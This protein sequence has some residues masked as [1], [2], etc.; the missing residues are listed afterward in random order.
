MESEQTAEVAT[1]H[2]ELPADCDTGT[3][4][5]VLE[6][7]SKATAAA[8][9]QFPSGDARCQMVFPPA[10]SKDTRKMLHVLAQGM[11]MPTFSKGLGDERRLAVHGVAFRD[12]PEME[13]ELAAVAARKKAPAALRER[14]KQIWR[15]C[16]ADGGALSDLSLGEIEEALLSAPDES[17]LPPH[18]KDMLERRSHGGRLLAAI[19][20]GD[21]ATALAVL[22]EHPRAAFIR[23]DPPP[24]AAHGSEQDTGYYP[25]HL[26][27]LGGLGDVLRALAAQG[28]QA[29]EVRDRNYAT[30]LKVAKKAGNTAAVELLLSLGAKDYDVGQAAHK[31]AAVSIPAGRGPHSGASQS[32]GQ[33]TLTG[34]SPATGS[35]PT[36]ASG[37]SYMSGSGHV[38]HGGSGQR[39]R[40]VS[41]GESSRAGQFHQQQGQGQ[42]QGQHQNAYAHFQHHGHGHGHHQ[43][44]DS[45]GS[46]GGEGHHPHQHPHGGAGSGRDSSHGSGA[47][48]GLSNRRRSIDDHGHHHHH[49]PQPGSAPAGAAAAARD[50]TVNPFACLAAVGEAAE[51]GDG[52][53]N[54]AG[55]AGGRSRRNSAMGRPPR[56]PGSELGSG[57]VSGLG[58][59]GSDSDPSGNSG[60]KADAPGGAGAG[61]GPSGGLS[62]LGSL[63]AG[64]AKL[65]V[66][67]GSNAS[68]AGLRAQ[69]PSIM[70]GDLD[71]DSAAAA[72][73]ALGLSCKPMLP[74]ADE[75]EEAMIA[76]AAARKKAAAAAARRERGDQE[77]GD[78]QEDDADDGGSGSGPDEADGPPGGS[79]VGSMVEGGTPRKRKTRRGRRGR[80]GRRHSMPNTEEAMAAAE[81]AAR[82]VNGVASAVPI[83]MAAMSA[84][85]GLD[86]N[87]GLVGSAPNGAAGSGA[88]LLSAYAARR[89]NNGTGRISGFGASDSDD[90]DDSD[91]SGGGSRSR[92][93]G[94]PARARRH[95][96]RRTARESGPGAGSD[97]A[98]GEG[99]AAGGR[100]S[101]RTSAGDYH[102]SGQGQAAKG[103]GQGGHYQVYGGHAPHTHAADEAVSWRRETAL[104]PA[105]GGPGSMTG[106]SGPMAARLAAAYASTTGVPGSPLRPDRDREARDGPAGLRTQSAAMLPN[107]WR[108][109]PQLRRSNMAPGSGQPGTPGSEQPNSPFHLGSAGIHGPR[110]HVAAGPSPGISGFGRGRGRGA[111]PVVGGPAAPG[112]QPGVPVAVNSPALAPRG[113]G[114]VAGA[115]AAAL[116]SPASPAFYRPALPA[117]TA[118]GGLPGGVLV[119][120][121]SNITTS[122]SVS[123]NVAAAVAAALA[124][125]PASPAARRTGSITS[126][127]GGGP[128]APLFTPADAAAAAAAVAAVLG[129]PAHRS[130]AGG[131]APAAAAPVAY[132]NSAQGEP[133]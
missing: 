98:A 107:A 91:G 89:S 65:R 132:M 28:S 83:R 29:L 79:R 1:R 131:R 116:A 15:W 122:P 92:R 106:A 27:A 121:S 101:R 33:V 119:R 57:H 120:T 85:A 80:G 11:G 70:S 3:I 110:E 124:P 82:A 105:A 14:A 22:A 16:Q 72:L 50:P 97:R 133:Q 51:A 115:V 61:G 75:E 63:G 10:L 76:A 112:S 62:G 12:T 48:S 95:E 130:P 81:A 52:G 54:G 44:N 55:A 7:F 64:L 4:R 23:D 108:A 2:F 49:H 17:L 94:Q 21:S 127:G 8:S 104:P 71:D 128:G 96:R 9:D 103:Q 102:H 47:P 109:L 41:H 111:A 60:L 36:A 35:S 59:A 32:S 56:P 77:G 73:A 20:A 118:G 125:P 93:G 117:S 19:K 74:T 113:S 6:W 18:V 66:A 30:P 40:R 123:A 46:F 129:S 45:G 68:A 43:R 25:V 58:D 37:G 38:G 88:Q 87:E 78:E 69:L 34:G 13:A 5:A 90:S 84:A 100:R 86:R 126:S 114:P 53:V 31:T 42:G 99:S 67:Y 26:A 24:G 39:Q